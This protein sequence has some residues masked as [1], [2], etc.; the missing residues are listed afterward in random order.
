MR[1]SSAL[2]VVPA[3]PRRASTNVSAP[4]VVI[5]PEAPPVPP[6]LPRVS[7]AAPKHRARNI[8][9]T[10]ILLFGGVFGAA[11]WWLH[12]TPVSSA[13]D[14]GA[15]VLQPT[16]L[17]D[18]T[19]VPAGST[20]VNV[21]PPNAQPPA[22]PTAQQTTAPV[23]PRPRP[24]T[25]RPAPNV[26]RPAA[27][28]AGL[29]D[30]HLLLNTQPWSEVYLDGVAVGNTPKTDLPVSPGTHHL[31]FTRDGFRPYE[32]SVVVGPGSS[33]RLTDIVLSPNTP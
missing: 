33:L 30:G 17:S 21:T 15:I 10:A 16:N 22:S 5:D 24:A 20:A 3:A 31:R 2:S 26:R 14:P 25:P 8:L 4:L 28:P 19:P 6:R 7:V 27:A 32:T 23:T 9:L 29:A 18:L 1:P 13:I 12:A 11:W